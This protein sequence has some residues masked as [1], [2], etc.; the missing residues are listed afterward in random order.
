MI[1][2]DFQTKSLFGIEFVILW[3]RLEECMIVYAVAE[4]IGGL[5]LRQEGFVIH[6]GTALS[7]ITSL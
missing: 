3:A 4:A 7:C 1:Y 2:I 6:T 5:I